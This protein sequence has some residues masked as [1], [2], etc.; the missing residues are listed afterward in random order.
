MQSLY[1]YLFADGSDWARIWLFR[2]K[3]WIAHNFLI[4]DEQKHFVP[5][6]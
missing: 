1:L 5:Y 2:R 4:I 6:F 3:V